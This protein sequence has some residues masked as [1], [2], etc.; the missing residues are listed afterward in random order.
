MNDDLI[1]MPMDWLMNL[2]LE[3]TPLQRF[4]MFF[5]IIPIIFLFQILL[6]FPIVGIY[7]I[8]RYIIFGDE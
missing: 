7:E 5:I 2:E 4:L 1:M 3:D 8:I 6:W